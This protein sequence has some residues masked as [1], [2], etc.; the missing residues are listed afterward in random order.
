MQARTKQGLH[1]LRR[2]HAFLTAREYDVAMGTLKPQIDALASLV[3]RLETHAIEQD[4]RARSARLRTN[5]KRDL[6]A[7]LRNEYLR[8][9][10]RLARS[11]FPNDRTLQAGFR[12]PRSRESEGLLQTA[13]GIAER[14]EEHKEHFIAKGLAPDFVERLRA[15]TVTYRDA[16]V[17]RGLDLGRRSAAS[18]GLL[19]DIARGRELVRLIDDMLAPRLASQR[20]LLAEWR[21]ITRFVRQGGSG[22]AEPAA[23]TPAT[24]AGSV[25][26]VDLAA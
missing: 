8:P 5:A 15:A 12:L 24:T 18:A 21:T 11:I 13:G 26:P 19:S 3:T 1:T 6:G 17:A 10:S 9:I 7:A 20:D 25:T 4:G 2:A 22:A 14:A 16:I 23:A